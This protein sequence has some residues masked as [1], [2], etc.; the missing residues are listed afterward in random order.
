MMVSPTAKTGC[1]ADAGYIRY[2][3][4]VILQPSIAMTMM[5]MMMTM[6]VVMMMMISISIRM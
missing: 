4:G 5:T 1:N 6:V 2:I 3:C